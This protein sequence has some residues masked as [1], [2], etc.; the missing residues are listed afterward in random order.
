MKPSRHFG[1]ARTQLSLLVGGLFFVLLG[2]ASQSARISAHPATAARG[3]I[4]FA[5]DI[6]PIFQKNCNTCHGATDKPQG[7]LRLDSE[8]AA[9]KG[10]ESGKVIVP[11][12]S[13]KSDLVKRLV[14][15]GEETRMPV[16]ADP[17]PSAQIKLIRA[18]IDQ[19]SFA[20][21]PESAGSPAAHIAPVTDH[22]QQ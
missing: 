8:A 1:R 18:W 16:G 3:K 2:A 17:L 19:N 21:P 12:D 15:N 9:L 10:G 6:E 14:G 22:S 20:V 4:T 5:R 7:G 11:G 13:E